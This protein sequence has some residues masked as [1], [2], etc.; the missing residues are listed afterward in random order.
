MT[1]LESAAPSRRL[2]RLASAVYLACFLPAAAG[3][4]LL[5]LHK[6]SLWLMLLVVAI[7]GSAGFAVLRTRPQALR[8]AIPILMF[9]LFVVTPEV[10]LRLLDFHYETGVQF[11]FPRRFQRFVRDPELFWTLPRDEPGVNRLGFHGPEVTSPKPAAVQRLLFLGDSVLAQGYPEL[12]GA[13]L[14]ARWPG[15]VFE[16]VNLSLQGYSSDQGKVLAEKYGELVDPDAVLICYGWNDH[17]LAWGS[18]DSEKRIAAK[19]PK[20]RALTESLY[21]RS[22]L[23]QLLRWSLRPVLGAETPSSQ[24][25]VPL[26]RYRENVTAIAARF[27]ERQVPVVL[28]TAPTSHDVL[29]VPAY[30]IEQQF[31]HEP[32]SVLALHRSYSQALREIAQR[33]G[34]ELLDLERELQASPEPAEIFSSDGIHLT[35]AGKRRVAERVAKLLVERG[36]LSEVAGQQHVA[37]QP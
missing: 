34:W 22:R 29:G 36:L 24:V 2:L 20:H 9:Q 32:Q 26:E 6:P 25:R 19:L 16:V 35:E 10:V 28:I 11:G 4:L 5:A 37:E 7:A 13:L 31:A 17:W 12:A 33:E 3:L 21:Q 30:L 14:Q 8:R 15:R 18:P 1:R 23:L 27:A